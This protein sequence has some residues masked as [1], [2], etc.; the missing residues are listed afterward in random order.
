MYGIF[1]LSLSSLRVWFGPLPYEICFL[2][3]W[4]GQVIIW[5]AILIIFCQSLAKFM[6]ICVWKRMRDMNDDLIVRIAFRWTLFISIWVRVHTV[7]EFH[8]QKRQN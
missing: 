7:V 2:H 8:T 1:V 5:Y 4:S 3:G 6:F